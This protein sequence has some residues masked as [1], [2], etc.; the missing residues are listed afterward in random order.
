[1]VVDTVMQIGNRRVVA[2]KPASRPRPTV[3]N[4]SGEAMRH[5]EQIVEYRRRVS[6]LSADLES[7]VQALSAANEEIAA[8]RKEIA[9][10][11]KNRDELVCRLEGELK[12]AN[13][14]LAVYESTGADTPVAQDL[15]AKSGRASKA[16]RQ[17]KEA[18]AEPLVEPRA[19]PLAEPSQPQG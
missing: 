5:H 16:R 18:V 1:M 3:I 11:A 8:L 10:M 19:E 9:A 4:I 13:D 2:T 14:R 7:A 17:K 15:P 6:T 12:T